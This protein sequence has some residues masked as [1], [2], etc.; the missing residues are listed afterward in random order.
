[1][2]TRYKMLEELGLDRPA[3]AV[4]AY[5]KMGRKEEWDYV[6]NK[7]PEIPPSFL[8]KVDF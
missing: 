2:A 6:Q 4:K 7:W 5:K 8:A 3:L 1:M